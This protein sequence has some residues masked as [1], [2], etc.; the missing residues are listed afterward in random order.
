MLSNLLLVLGCAL[1]LVGGVKVGDETRRPKKQQK[2]NI[3]TAATTVRFS[4][5]RSIDHTMMHTQQQQ[6]G[7]LLLL[8]TMGM[9]FPAL[10]SSTG[11][12]IIQLQISSLHGHYE[13]DQ[14][15]KF[16]ME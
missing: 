4:I 3:I 15:K 1:L 7:A 2:F 9:I 8:A 14:E 13:E 6:N 12:I 10:L 16:Q 5:F 11:I